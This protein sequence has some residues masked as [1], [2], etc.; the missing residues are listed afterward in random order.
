[1]ESKVLDALEA[2]V[3]YALC[4]MR[5]STMTMVTEEAAKLF[6]PACMYSDTGLSDLVAVL[7]SESGCDDELSALFASPLR[8]GAAPEDAEEEPAAEEDSEE[9]AEETEDEEMEPAAADP[10]A[11]DIEAHLTRTVSES[12][13][14]GFA[15]DFL[16][17]AFPSDAEKRAAIAQ[18]L[19]S[20]GERAGGRAGGRCYN[21]AAASR[22]SLTPVRAVA[23]QRLC[24][25]SAA[26]CRPCGMP[27]R[28]PPLA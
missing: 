13:L 5:E 26:I 6:L 22:A 10:E 11:I 23:V 18:K 7:K 12:D 8:A 17:G 2:K 21:I 24:A 19:R 28:T 27:G 1:M 25:L 15:D 4:R 9:D 3:K 16:A 20:P 14:V